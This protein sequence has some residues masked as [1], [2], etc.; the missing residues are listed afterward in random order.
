MSYSLSIIFFVWCIKYIILASVFLFCHKN[1][2]DEE[3]YRNRCGYIYENLNLENGGWALAYPIF[4]KLRF[5][6][7]VFLFLNVKHLF[8]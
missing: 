2:L 5:V 6:L 3:R 8:I 4:Y 1:N 7:I